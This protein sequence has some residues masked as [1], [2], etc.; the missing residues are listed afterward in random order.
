MHIT[1]SNTTTLTPPPY[2]RWLKT[3]IKTS[4]V[5]RNVR[6]CNNDNDDDDDDEYKSMMI[7]ITI[8]PSVI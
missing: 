8:T 2:D 1:N 4:A 3:A 6:F 7:I 5:S